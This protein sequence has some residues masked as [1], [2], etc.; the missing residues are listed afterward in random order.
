MNIHEQLCSRSLPLLEAYE[1][2]LK[3][4]KDW[5]DNN[6][7]VPFLHYTRA[8]GTH[9]IPLNPSNTYPPAGTKVKY[10]FG[11]ADRDIILQ[12][13]LEMQDWFE[14]ALREPPRLTLNYD[15]RTLQVVTLSKAREILEDYARATRAEWDLMVSGIA[16]EGSI[17]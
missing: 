4:D 16:L 13:K 1:T 5:I 11:M 12:G 9:L 2:D 3:H 6:P 10:L 7:G 17:I 8:T 14:N 15:G